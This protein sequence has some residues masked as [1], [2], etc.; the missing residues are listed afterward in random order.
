MISCKLP[1]IQEQFYSDNDIAQM[2]SDMNGS[3][4]EIPGT[5]N[6]A[7]DLTNVPKEII[8]A[9]I[10]EE[11]RFD[12]N[13]ISSAGAI[14]YMQLKPQTANDVIYLESKKGRMSDQEKAEIIKVI[15]DKRFNNIINMKYLG[16]TANQLTVDD[17]KNGFFNILCGSMFLG[18]LIDE[19]TSNGILS[20]DSAFLR[21][22]KGY[23]YHPIGNNIVDRLSRLNK[24]SEAYQYIIKTVGI[25]GILT[26]QI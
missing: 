6:Y 13:A 24:S 5:I 7:S 14:G 20:I 17:L 19:C 12:S 23:F 21:Y 11:S 9:I 1:A 26:K 10:Y 4:N 22:A 2:I 8:K 15:G 3:Y 18:I 25:N 16:Y